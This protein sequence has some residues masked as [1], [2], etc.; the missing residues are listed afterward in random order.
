MRL[1]LYIALFTFFSL[2]NGYSQV[3]VLDPG[4]GY[5]NDCTQNC[6]S[7]VRSDIEILTAMDVGNKLTALL[8]ACPTVTTYL[9]RTSNACGDFPSLSQ[10]AAMSNSWGADRFLSIHCNAG[11]GTGT[12]TFW[13]DNSPSS[14]IACEDFATEVQTQMVDYGEWNYRRVVEDF[15]YLNFHLGVLSPTNAV[16]TLSEIGFVDSADATKLQDDGWRN[17]FALAYLV[18]LQNDLGITTCSEL[19]CGNPIVLT[20][21]TVYNGSSA[22]NPSNVDAYGCNNWTETGPERV[23]TISPTSSGV[24]TAT[25]SNFTGD[26]DVYILGSCNPN[27]CL[28][29]VSS[30]SATYADAIAGQTY[31]IIVDADDG[32]GSAYDLLVTCPNEDIYLN[33]IS[34]DLNTIAPTY[35]LTINCT[36]NYSGTASN[37]PNSYV[38]YYLS[39]D[40]VLD[41]SDI[42][43]D[44]QIFSSLNASNTSDTIVNSVTIPEGTSAGNYNILL[45]SDATNVISESDEVNNISCIPITVTEPQLDCSN[46]ITLT[47]G[48]PYNGTSS[49]DISHI[50]SYACNSWTETGPERVHTIVSPGNGTITAAI[51]NFTGELDVYILGSCDPNDCL[52]T[53]ASSSATFTGA[54]AGH[55]YYIVV[56]ADDGSGSAYDL[57]VTCPTPLLSELGI[58][59]FLEGPFT[60]P[61]DNG[62][63]N[64][65]LRSGVY[66]P[67]LSPYADA[68]TIDTNILN[69]TGTNAIVDW[70]WVELRDAADNTNIITSTSALLQRDGD[71]VDVNGTSNLTFT[72]PYDNYY[73]TVSHRNH[74]GIMSANAIPLSSN[75]NSIDFTSDPNITLGGVN[76]LT[77]INGEYTLIGGDFDENGQAQTADVIAITLL[78]GGAGYSNA[79]LDMNGQIQTTDVNNICYPNLGKG[80]QF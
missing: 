71:I 31:Y 61:T 12:E 51:S 64:D 38:Y 42:L 30:S 68:L 24:L 19:D 26:L 9:T 3:I 50:G 45:F 11:G 29:T 59:V 47:C 35:D 27:D 79:D 15:S 69:T 55:T 76:A 78:L 77:N 34:S 48:V 73:V 2:Y 14:N 7:A 70:V 20:C 8:Q 22:T 67:T 52:G 53:V 57:V 37:V 41:G 17:Q 13:C 56:D 49:S 16:G 75:P 10:R 44:N 54:V 23:H 36:Q 74:I 65:D 5:C 25:I 18:A 60:S 58:N 28:G 39:T 72:V 46:P 33:N 4:H 1:K 21:D 62:L 80:Q 63:M 6:T 32:S 40:C 43:L 66:I